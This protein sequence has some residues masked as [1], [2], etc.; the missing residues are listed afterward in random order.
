MAV[1]GAIEV[2]VSANTARFRE[3]MGR[4]AREAQSTATQIKGSLEEINK[5]FSFAREGVE[6]LVAV[7]AVER[8]ASFAEKIVETATQITNMANAAGVSTTAFQELT[9]AGA[10]VG[11]SQEQI[12]GALDKLG[13]HIGAAAEG[14]RQLQREFRALGIAFTDAAGAARNPADVLRDL[15]GVL[16][17][18]PDQARRM[19][20][21]VAF[22]GRGMEV[23][24]PLLR[25]GVSGLDAWMNKAE[26]AG[27]VMDATTARAL[28]DLGTSWDEFNR[29]LAVRGAQ[30]LVTEKGVIDQFIAEAQS[31]F[32]WWANNVQKTSEQEGVRLR[33][34]QASD[35]AD[36]QAHL[37]D[38][39]RLAAAGAG[40]GGKRGPVET[41]DKQISDLKD[42]IDIAQ[43][44]LAELLATG[45]GPW[46]GPP[47][48]PVP[49]GLDLSKL[50]GPTT[51]T[52]A[53][54]R[55]RDAEAIDNVTK[56]LT[57]ELAV[58]RG[59]SD[60]LKID[61]DLREAHT[62]A[63]TAG[64]LT[65]TNLEHAIEAQ[66]KANAEAKKQEE[67]HN[68]AIERGVSLAQS[69]A[70][71]LEKYRADIE[72]LNLALNAGK[73][74]QQQWSAAVDDAF[75]KL[76]KIDPAYK[77]AE[78]A[79]ADLTTALEDTANKIETDLTD[80]LTSLFDGSTK[81]ADAWRNA[82]KSI[83]KDV[84]SM[85]EN[86]AKQ[87]LGL[88]APGGGIGSLLGNALGSL[89]GLSGPSAGIAAQAASDVAVL[90]FFQSGGQLG[91]GQW[92]VVGEH[93]PELIQANQPSTILPNH[94][95][96]GGGGGNVSIVLNAQGADPA[97]VGRL[98]RLVD[99]LHRTFEPRAI[100]A[101]DRERKRGGQLARSF[102]R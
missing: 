40:V 7:F 1:I 73:I 79:Q 42:K 27:N 99:Q 81:S 88:S 89:L 21:E 70:P 52:A 80:A 49:P 86:L 87:A 23:L 68:K 69:L 36:M 10:A 84:G 48:A 50:F 22:L 8:I 17:K 20:I 9:S 67:E 32:D 101:V 14:N 59:H 44:K 26:E 60:Q 38:L 65:I 46:H 25:G 45:F 41:L 62:T 85:L 75:V 55:K 83:L 54:K 63:D 39:Q 66:T 47:P 34:Q 31:A 29:H 97:S 77:A 96:G 92:G 102:G 37:A 95:L 51:D 28:T 61:T 15:A 4:I 91:A 13:Q 76:Q 3:D 57:D 6:A 78:K 58:L 56:R 53:E 33:A 90:P 11:V 82:L 19:A 43:R 35:L 5:A 94:M 16:G 18:V 64:G 93:G 74:S 100:A 71:P 2:D 30:M 24:D 98:E 72:A 12:S